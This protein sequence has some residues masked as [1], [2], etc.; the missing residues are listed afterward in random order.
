MRK[1]DTRKQG[2]AV[3]EFALMLALL[4]VPLMAGV[5][6]ISKFIDIN[7]ILT[8]AAR[9]GVVTASRGDDP[10]AQMQDYIQAAGLL[11]SHLSVTVEHGAEEPVLGQEVRVLLAYDFSGYTIFPWE[12][13]MP[14]G[15]TTAASAKME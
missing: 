15:V 11:P 3:I 1:N 7:Q 5:W 9:E 12:D 10:T 6:D 14:E 13:F 2:I 4:M 8:R